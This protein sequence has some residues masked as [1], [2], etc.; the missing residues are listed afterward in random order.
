MYF[1][2]VHVIYYLAI[3]ILGAILGKL[4]NWANYRL[5]EHKKV[6]SLDFF[7]SQKQYKENYLVIL[8]N[9]IINILILYNYGIQSTI[10]ANLQ[11]IK[12]LILTPM[13]LSAFV[14]DYR[15]QII[16]NRRNALLCSSI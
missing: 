6:L 4:I 1:N 15:L 3:T 5:P 7:R 14:I 13:L 11:L 10:I 12:Y 16:P 9:I 8:A 2:D